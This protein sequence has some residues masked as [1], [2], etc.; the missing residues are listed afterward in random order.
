MLNN[1]LNRFYDFLKLSFYYYIKIMLFHYK[2]FYQIRIYSYI[3]SK[4]NQLLTFDI[5]RILIIL[6]FI[7][8]FLNLYFY[9]TFYK[10][11]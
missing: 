9:F 5:I 1:F 2:I 8:R 7:T 10:S 6:F 3:E 4:L 11:K